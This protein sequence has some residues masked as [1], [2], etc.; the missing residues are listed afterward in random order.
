MR[1]TIYFA[2]E[3]EYFSGTKIDQKPLPADHKYFH[4]PIWNALSWL[5][6]YLIAAPVAFLI[7]KVWYREKVIGKEKLR[8]YKKQGFFLYGNHTRLM[9]DV[10]CPPMICY[11][12]KVHIIANPD[13]VSIPVLGCFP[14]M[15]GCV[16]LPTDRRGVPNFHA[17]IK[18]HAE[19]GHVVS[20]FPEAK[21][22]PYY[23]KIRP[24][25]SGS[26]RY[27]VETGKPVFC[28]T[29]THQKSKFCKRPK[30]V[31][32]IDGPFLVDENLSVKEKQKALYEAVKT[33]MEERA[34][35]SN[36]EYIEYIKKDPS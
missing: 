29:V 1:K 23:T 7:Q 15:L 14:E 13:S 27:P 31:T 12:K 26:F 35:E 33:C 3:T 16:P 4:G 25:P 2:D 11:P 36:Y 21:I 9:G 34:K 5:I 18:K 8:G 30:S 22:W 17:A 20:I 28:M 32:Y 24:F 10:F 19:K 6:Y